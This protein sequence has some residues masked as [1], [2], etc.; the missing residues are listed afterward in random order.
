MVLFPP[1][2]LGGV[3]ARRKTQPE[4]A[5]LFGVSLRTFQRWPHAWRI[6][7]LIDAIRTALKKVTLSFLI[8]WLTHCRYANMIYEERSS[9]YMPARVRRPSTHGISWWCFG[10]NCLC[11]YCR[12]KL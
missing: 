6:E 4:I 9:G 8:G 12:H 7:E 2:G 10:L 3:R 11:T 1:T 5:A